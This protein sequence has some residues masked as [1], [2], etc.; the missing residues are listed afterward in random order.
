MKKREQIKSTIL[1]LKAEQKNNI[2]KE[3]EQINMD[4]DVPED[5]QKNSAEDKKKNGTKDNQPDEDEKKK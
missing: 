1:R 4:E 5:K 2:I 3:D